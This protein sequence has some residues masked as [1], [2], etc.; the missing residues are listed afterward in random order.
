MQRGSYVAV[1]VGVLG[2]ATGGDSSVR[3]NAAINPIDGAESVDVNLQIGKRLVRARLERDSVAPRL[4][5]EGMNRGEDGVR[6][7][8]RTTTTGVGGDKTRARVPVR[9]HVYD[10]ST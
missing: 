9:L 2:V 1:V 3:G 4:D 5:V 6:I 8:A 7:L 10:V